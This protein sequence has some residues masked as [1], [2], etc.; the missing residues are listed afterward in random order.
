M[1]IPTLFTCGHSYHSV[2]AFRSSFTIPTWRVTLA[3]VWVG[4]ASRVLRQAGVPVR[5]V[6]WTLDSRWHLWLP[7][8]LMARWHWTLSSREMFCLWAHRPTYWRTMW[9]K[10]L[11]CSTKMWVFVCFVNAVSIT[12]VVCILWGSRLWEQ[13]HLSVAS[14]W[15]K[16]VGSWQC[17][18]RRTQTG[19]CGGQ[20]LC[21]RLWFWGERPILD[22]E[23]LWRVNLCECM[24][25]FCWWWNAVG[26]SRWGKSRERASI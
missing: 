12:Y 19:V 25:L 2:F 7:Q 23:L 1:L 8:S 17:K 21:S 14:W 16:C 18:E 10:I 24:L 5:W 11:T 3:A 26:W 4:A 9:S 13:V 22:C 20:L 15:S 6:C